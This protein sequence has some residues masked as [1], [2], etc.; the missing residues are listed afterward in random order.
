MTV[1]I[2]EKRKFL[3]ART[4]LGFTLLELLVVVAIVGFLSSISIVALSASQAHNRDTQRKLDQISIIKAAERY[5]NDSGVYPA[6]VQGFGQVSLVPKVQNELN[7]TSIIGITPVLAQRFQPRDGGGGGGPNC[8][9]GTVQG[10][11][12]CDGGSVSCAQFGYDSG[13]AAC[14]ADCTGYITTSCS[15][16][17]GNG[18]LCTTGPGV[19][20]CD[21]SNLNNNDG[22][23]SS[24]QNEYCGD[25]VCQTS[26]SCSSCASDCGTC[27]PGGGGGTYDQCYQGGEWNLCCL[28]GGTYCQGAGG[29]PGATSG[30][31]GVCNGTQCE[32]RYLL[33][34]PEF[35][36]AQ[37]IDCAPPDI[38]ASQKF[39][40]E[41]QT[42]WLQGLTDDYLP[43]L[44]KDPSKQKTSQT[45]CGN[46]Y[47]SSN[48]DVVKQH[49]FC[50]YVCYERAESF[51]PY[52]DLVT[53]PTDDQ[54]N[55]VSIWSV[56]CTD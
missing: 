27:Q 39:V 19:E 48:P 20:Q 2:S 40:A 12:V 8:G 26:E 44:P 14:K 9:D 13:T 4:P 17:C 15:C 23:N 43:G 7:L 38:Q 32:Q 6:Q 41:S 31:Y 54:V 1:N 45:G 35:T 49:G 42:N 10:S 16:T 52:P 51:N 55:G 30:Y 36:C 28:F 33:Q 3:V 53:M 18:I 5:K 22:C 21:D 37:N 29:Q 56:L 47:A 25:A 50:A 46:Y 34:P 24:C 11:E